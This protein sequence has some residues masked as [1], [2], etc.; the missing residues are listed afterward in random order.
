MSAGPVT[1]RPPVDPGLAQRQPGEAA[2]ES[3]EGGASFADLLAAMLAPGAAPLAEPGTAAPGTPEAVFDR[4]DSAEI[5][6]EAGLFRGAAPLAAASLDPGLGRLPGTPS[7][8]LPSDAALEVEPSALAGP[9]PVPADAEPG[10]ASSSARFVLD[11]ALTGSPGAGPAAS[12]AGA[13]GS[14]PAPR[15]HPAPAPMASSQA[16]E[17]APAGSADPVRASSRRA[18]MLVQ[19]HLAKAASTSA[20]VSAQAVEAGISLVVRADKLGRE[21]RD[22]LRVEIAELLLSHGFAMAEMTLNGEAWPVPHRKDD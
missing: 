11:A 21:E 15:G 4:L 14:A 7:P 8:S 16:P 12:A 20:Q 1:S 19:A 2:S 9:G 10:P 17:T 6:N 18:V 5:F 22:R 13:A 3:G